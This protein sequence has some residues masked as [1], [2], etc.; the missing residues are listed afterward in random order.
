M[1]KKACHE[2]RE[3]WSTPVVEE[4]RAAPILVSLMKQTRL[5]WYRATALVAAVL[6]SLL[7]LVTFLNGDTS[8]FSEPGFWRSILD[9][10]VMITYILVVYPFMWRLFKQAIEAFR[11]ISPVEESDFNRLVAEITTPNRHREL[12]VL[13]IGAVFALLLNLPWSASMSSDT[14]LKVYELILSM[15]LF[16]LLG[17]LIYDTIVGTMRIA[18]LSGQNLKLDIFNTNLLSPVA[19]WSL[20][21]SLA[22]VGGISLS[23]VFQ[24]RE[25]MTQWQNIT[26]YAILVS[27]TVLVFFLSMWSTHKAMVTIKKRELSLAWNNLAIASRELKSRTAQNQKEGMEELSY[28]ITAWA[29][30]HKL[31]RETSAWPFNASIIRRLGVSILAPITVF[32]IETMTRGGIS[33]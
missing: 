6:L 25:S 30:Q 11:A 29:A 3:S 5:P 27:A 13:F 9:G 33:L 17:W 2:D 7:I 14:L 18:R 10:P 15:L 19:V 24:N 4:S 16:G 22:W 20:G 28:T 1:A 21:I 12:A 32:L 26:I 23:L 8:D 31:V